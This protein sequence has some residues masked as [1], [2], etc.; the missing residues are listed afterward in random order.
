[1]EEFIDYDYR[2]IFDTI[3]GLNPILQYAACSKFLDLIRPYF[4]IYNLDA[5]NKLFFRA[6]SHS[7]VSKD[8]YF[9]NISELSFRTDFFNITSAGRCNCP[10]ES[11]FYCSDHPIIS[12]LE[13]TGLSE[14]E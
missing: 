9:C 13:I 12:F 2:K 8:F 1:M 5:E 7:S 4:C 3:R 14:R 11:I 6:R 10:F